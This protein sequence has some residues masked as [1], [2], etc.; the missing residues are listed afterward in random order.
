VRSQTHL[1]T[2]FQ[3]NSEVCAVD[4][5][6]GRI[7]DLTGRSDGSPPK[8]GTAKSKPLAEFGAG[9]AD[10]PMLMR[11][12][13]RKVAS[14]FAKQIRNPSYEGYESLP[15]HQESNRRSGRGS[16]C[17]EGKHRE[18]P[19]SDPRPDRRQPD[20]LVP[21]NRGPPR[22]LSMAGLPR[23][24]GVRGQATQRRGQP[25]STAEIRRHTQ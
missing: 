13:A 10:F 14:E 4:E 21:A 7:P 6:I 12:L 1:D 23:R 9:I 11:F 24:R 2:R 3:G 8:E 22:L 16:A 25:G 18:G 15:G 19:R 5:L 20:P 17:E